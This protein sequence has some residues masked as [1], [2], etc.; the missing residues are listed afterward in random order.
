MLCYAKASRARS[1]IEVA[2]CSLII[3]SGRRRLPSAWK[4]AVVIPITKPG[5]NPSKPSSYRP[6]ANIKSMQDNGK[7]GNR[8]VIV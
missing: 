1:I 7:D 8:K 6:I 5:T 2:G 4:E 3:K